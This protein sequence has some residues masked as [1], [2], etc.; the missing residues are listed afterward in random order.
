MDNK[1]QIQQGLSK[2]FRALPKDTTR[3]GVWEGENDVERFIKVVESSTNPSTTSTLSWI[4]R[5]IEEYDFRKSTW[6]PKEDLMHIMNSDRFTFFETPQ[7]CQNAMIEHVQQR[8]NS[9]DISP[10]IQELDA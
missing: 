10:I 1:D 6:E 3:F 5:S 2:A 4:P 8:L 7:D 9:P